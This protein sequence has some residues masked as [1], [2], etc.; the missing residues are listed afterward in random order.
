MD[1]NSYFNNTC[2]MKGRLLFSRVREEAAKPN[3]R[4]L[5]FTGARQTG[6]TTLS[7]QAFPEYAYLSIEDP[8]TRADYRR[9]TS[10]QWRS[11]YPK[12]ILDEVQKEPQLIESIKA[13]WDQWAE[14]RYILLGSSQLLLLDKVRESLAGRC[15][16]IEMFPLTL[17]ELRTQSLDQPVELSLF[18]KLLCRE[19]VPTLSPSLNL[20]PAGASKLAAWGHYCRVGGYPALTDPQLSEEDQFRW[21][22][23]YVQ[24]YLERDVRDL[25]NFRDLEPFVRLQQWTAL[26]TG[27]TANASAAALE[28]GVDV[29]TVQ[30]YLRYL[31]LS[32]QAL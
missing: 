25:A 18:Q 15:Q 13:V 14:P 3:G 11:L 29:K 27:T 7:R 28:V 16:I 24:T 17:P 22:T 19:S 10:A 23:G 1:K 2:P 31:V 30:R 20:D 32:Y 8:V 12:A 9:L 4:I 5:V 21:L 26:R 6:K